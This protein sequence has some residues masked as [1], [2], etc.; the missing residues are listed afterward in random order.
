MDKWANDSDDIH[1]EFHELMEDLIQPKED[2]GVDTEEAIHQLAN[3]IES[4]IEDEDLYY[5]ILYSIKEEN[6]EKCST[7]GFAQ[8]LLIN[9]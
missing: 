5:E 3:Y 7:V 6:N 2:Y 8:W 4:I 1:N 9:Y